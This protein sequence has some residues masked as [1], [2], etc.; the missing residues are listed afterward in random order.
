L[1]LINPQSSAKLSDFLPAPLPCLLC[2]LTGMVKKQVQILQCCTHKWCPIS[3]SGQ[4][5]ETI[6]SLGYI[7]SHYKIK[8][9]TN[10][11]IVLGKWVCQ[12]FIYGYIVT[13]YGC[14]CLNYIF[15]KEVCIILHSTYV[16]KFW[17][18]F[19]SHPKFY[20]KT[21]VECKIIQT[22]LGNIYFKQIHPYFV[23]IYPLINVWQTHLPNTIHT[24]APPFWL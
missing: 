21:Y 9:G 24:L 1:S 20:I 11:C 12:T 4:A 8:G 13:K 19:T 14:N 5:M 10:V 3:T 6:I 23:T 7:L 16:P 2:P 22:S 17:L 15:P 18:Y